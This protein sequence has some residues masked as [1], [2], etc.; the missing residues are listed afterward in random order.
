MS[1]GAL[2]IADGSGLT[3]L[4]AINAAIA[5]LAT[6]ASGTARPSDIGTGEMWIE[7]DNPGGGTWS[8]WFYDGST[9]ILQGTVNTST[10][11]WTP[12]A[13]TQTAGDNS[14]KVATTAYADA[15]ATPA[16]GNIFGLEGSTAGSSTTLTVSAG[17][18]TDSTHARSLIRAASLA[19]T[20]SAWVVGAGGGLDTGAIANS[21][22]YHWYVIAK[23]DLS[24]VDVI[25]STSASAPTLPATYTLYRRIFSWQTNGSAQWATFQQFGDRFYR[26]GATDINT[27]AVG[28]TLGALSVPSGIVVIPFGYAQVACLGSSGGSTLYL[29][30]G[31][32]AASGGIIAAQVDGAAASTYTGNYVTAPPTNTSRQVYYAASGVS[33]YAMWTT[34]GWIDQRG[35]NS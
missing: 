16:A 2:T 9:D 29:Y 4:A 1:Q 34:T 26:T 31:A 33:I 6:G 5:R 35:R 7:T 19:K 3:V 15:A 22:W 17:R 11:V 21:T 28:N 27:A 10:H 14:T 12:V 24:V 30:P 23:A 25:F 13:P 8:V 18:A 32:S 20:T